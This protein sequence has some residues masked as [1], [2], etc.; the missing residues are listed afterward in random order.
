MYFIKKKTTCSII[1]FV[2]MSNCMKREMGLQADDG[3]RKVRCLDGKW[4]ERCDTRMQ[5]D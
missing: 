2:S 3:K 4:T 1:L 5:E